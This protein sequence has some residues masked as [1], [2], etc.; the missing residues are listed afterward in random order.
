M[1]R[2]RPRRAPPSPTGS[3]NPPTKDGSYMLNIRNNGAGFK[4]ERRKWPDAWLK[5]LDT[6]IVRVLAEDHPQSVR[7]VF[8]RLTDPTRP[9]YVAKAESGYRRVQHRLLKLRESGRVPYGWI[10][11]STRLGHHVRTHS[12]GGAFLADVA[13]LYRHDL[14]A[15]ADSHVE[16]WCESRSIAGVIQRETR[17][18]AV[19]L[20]PSG[21]FSSVTFTWEAAQ[22]I[23]ASPQETAVVLYVGDYDPAG[24]L[25]DKNI[26]AN[27]RSHT[28]KPLIF[29][30]L[31]INQKQIAEHNLPAKPRKTRDTRSPNVTET[32][33]AEAM[34]AGI[35]RS[36]VRQAVESY[37]PEGALRAA[38][39]AEEA[40]RA[41]LREI[42]WSLN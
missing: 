20:Y 6:E 4:P 19:S 42:G 8:Y 7:H 24:V 17:K 14:W 5:S 18:M 13:G 12:S 9:V 1:D 15:A 30:R 23:N 22:Q 16:V 34:P 39:V 2:K 32:V 36:M 21:G 38:R 37:L 10:V 31:A 28:D 27:L 35:L 3:N 41:T 26:E 25:I 33:E 29:R 40:E 11:D